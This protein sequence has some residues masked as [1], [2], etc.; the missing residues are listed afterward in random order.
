M[1]EKLAFP[2]VPWLFPLW[3]TG[4]FHVLD[5]FPKV[6]AR[7]ESQISISRFFC[8]GSLFE[9]IV[10]KRPGRGQSNSLTTGIPH[11]AG[12][13]SHCKYRLVEAATK[14]IWGLFTHTNW[15]WLYIYT[16]KEISAQIISGSPTETRMTTSKKWE[17]KREKNWILTTKS[18][19][20][21]FPPLNPWCS[22]G[23]IHF[24]GT[25][26]TGVFHI[27]WTGIKPWYL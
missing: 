8:S 3:K 1:K 7:W 2:L 14:T 16:S 27:L 21:I 23:S 12:L 26:C 4:M 5:A 11:V 6:F 15:Y 25:Y 20:L 13:E 9:R 19:L 17:L 10:S 22:L 24:Q 18:L